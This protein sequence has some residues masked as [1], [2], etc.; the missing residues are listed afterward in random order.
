MTNELP[1][2]EPE[3]FRRQAHQLVDWMA[4]Y[5]RRVG[6]LPVQPSAPPG[7]V[8]S[9]LPAEAP[10][11]PEG[12]ERI[13]RDFEA[14]IMP[15][16]THWGH[17]RFFAYFPAN[18]SPPSILAEMLTAT[19]G[20]QCMSWN[21]SPAATELEQ[22]TM[23]WLRK[24][25][26]LPD[27]FTGVIQDTAST[28]TLVALI[29]AR[30][31]ALRRHDAKAP[32]AD[33]RRHGEPPV[34]IDRLTVYASEEA[35]SSVAKGARMAGFGPDRVRAIPADDRFAMRETLLATA[36]E[37]DRKAGLI[38]ACVVATVGTTSTTGIDPVPAIAAMC[39]R[40]SIWLHIDAAWGG[41]AAIL[42]E[43][44][45]IFEG[46]DQADSLV[47]NPH[48]WMLVNFD[49]TAYFVRDRDALRR[50]FA[51]SPAFLKA[52][53]DDRVVNYRD[54]GIQLGRRFRSLKLWFVIRTY[55][56][57]G[58]RAMIREHIRLGR[59]LAE[60][61]EQDGRFELMAPA[62]LALVVFRYLGEDAGKGGVPG[63]EREIDTLNERLLQRLHAGGRIMLTQTRAKGKYAIRLA[64]GHLT[65]RE[66]DVRSA[67]ETIRSAAA[68]LEDT[69]GAG[70][71]NQGRGE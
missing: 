14:I 21:T 31:E 67:W 27:A 51:T 30:D 15:G 25:V 39:R 64:L 50:S 62:P 53:H 6:T 47:F 43:M 23:D 68:E 71:G 66:E 60:W 10:D 36:I 16:M 52:E 40:E 57:D 55:G 3:V 54:W 41:S 59:L 4:D 37:A 11:R 22:V 29:T 8:R 34:S 70:S 24:L 56:V 38:P 18:S 48:K 63:G 17:P 44:R 32:G 13:I 61:V 65:T 49:C 19:L 33:P 35:H 45:W 28:A 5:L 58:I 1:T 42:P 12:F 26:G 46:A 7:A 69:G 2:L 20:A 9:Q